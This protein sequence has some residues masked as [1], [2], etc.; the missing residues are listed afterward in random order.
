MTVHK[1]LTDILAKYAARDG[2]QT[3]TD[4][5]TDHTYGTLVGPAAGPRNRS[6]LKS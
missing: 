3:G 5:N 6:A 2:G 1:M 4:K